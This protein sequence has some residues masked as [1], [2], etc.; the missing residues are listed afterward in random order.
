MELTEIILL[1]VGCVMFVASFVLP[2][3]KRSISSEDIQ[4]GE[5]QV[6]K[7]VDQEMQDAR[8]RI[9][10]IVD[11][12][13]ADGV[14]KTERSLDRLSNE[15]IMAVN[16]YS[17]T[18]LES[19][20]TNHKEVM[21]LYDMLN[22]KQESLKEAIRDANMAERKVKTAADT[23]EEILSKAPQQV[24]TEVV[25]EVVTEAVK[26]EVAVP[27]EK[28]PETSVPAPKKK[29]QPAKKTPKAE[30]PAPS[31]VTDKAEVDIN[32][33]ADDDNGRN[34]NDRILA[35]HK[36]GK[37]NMAIAKELGLGIGEVKLVIDLFEG[38]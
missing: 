26:E 24:V 10:D 37:S 17:D 8:S 21:F 5:E 15:K 12:K 36:A 32:F 2:E 19:I 31:N 4:L 18:V 34:N 20:N 23:A 38:M 14:E 7:L 28:V 1:I 6:K 29:R 33:T 3:K 9:S 25:E 27:E 22:N 35:L 13:I 11:E 30:K 16:E